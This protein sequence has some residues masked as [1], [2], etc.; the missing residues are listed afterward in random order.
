MPMPCWVPGRPLSPATSVGKGRRWQVQAVTTI[1]GSG[2]AV[3]VRSAHRHGV[4]AQ[5]PSSWPPSR[6]GWSAVKWAGLTTSA[7]EIKRG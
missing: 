6:L 7:V 4:Y 1:S 3:I 2:W 5:C